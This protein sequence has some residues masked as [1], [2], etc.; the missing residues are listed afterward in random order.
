MNDEIIAPIDY[1]KLICDALIIRG[2]NLKFMEQDDGWILS[3][4]FDTPFADKL[5]NL[6]TYVPEL[7]VR[8]R[9][10]GDVS[11][12][13]C[14]LKNIQ[15]NKIGE[16][17][18]TLND[19]MNNYNFVCLYVDDDRDVYCSYDFK[20]LGTEDIAI[21][22]FLKMFSVWQEI[23]NECYPHVLVATGNVLMSDIFL[24]EELT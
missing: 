3:L 7:H 11:M 19:L 10:D 5:I 1:A 21:A 2:L 12:W 17:K 9:S 22:Q 15:S 4:D 6:L 13:Y 8:L 20:L 16:V 24:N 23:I 18:N 14:F